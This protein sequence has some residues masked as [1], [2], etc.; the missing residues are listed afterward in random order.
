M[1]GEIIGVKVTG[2]TYKSAFSDFKIFVSLTLLKALTVFFIDFY[3]QGS[4]LPLL[5]LFLCSVLLGLS[6]AEIL[7]F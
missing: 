3:V 4:G 5:V 7:L 2:K 1:G 6:S